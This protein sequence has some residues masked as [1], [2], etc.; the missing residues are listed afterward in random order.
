MVRPAVSVSALFVFSTSTNMAPPQSQ[1]HVRSIWLC[2][3]SISHASPSPYNRHSANLLCRKCLQQRC[4]VLMYTQR[5]GL[6]KALTK[7]RGQS[8]LRLLPCARG[9]SRSSRR[10]CGRWTPLRCKTG[11]AGSPSR[12]S[13]WRSGP[14]TLPR[15]STFT[16]GT[17]D[18]DDDDDD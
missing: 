18:D 7:R 11:T 2:L 8:E 3:T 12:P 10:F 4:T 9:C 15:G 17:Y 5:S 6:H 1:V 13:P 14:P 16:V